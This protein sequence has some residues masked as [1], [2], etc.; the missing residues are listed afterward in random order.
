MATDL[1]RIVGPCDDRDIALAS[2]GLLVLSRAGRST[3]E[4][5]MQP[6]SIGEHLFG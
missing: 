1:R 2:R 4:S 5:V 3:A 6:S